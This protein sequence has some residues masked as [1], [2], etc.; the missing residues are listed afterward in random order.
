MWVAH[1]RALA[2]HV[3]DL[4]ARGVSEDGCDCMTNLFAEHALVRS[5][6]NARDLEESCLRTVSE[7]GIVSYGSASCVEIA[8]RRTCSSGRRSMREVMVRT[9]VVLV[10]RGSCSIVVVAGVLLLL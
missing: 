6:R 3:T 2:T 9:V 5:Y 4:E 10:S 7:Q 1:T 8:Q